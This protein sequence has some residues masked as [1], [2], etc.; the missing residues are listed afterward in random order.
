MKGQ[1]NARILCRVYRELISRSSCNVIWRTEELEKDS[2]SKIIG[3][4]FIITL[5]LVLVEA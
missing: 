4:N 1:N 3:Y 5:C 2:D